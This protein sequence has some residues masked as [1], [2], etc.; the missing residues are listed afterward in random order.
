[1]YVCMYVCTIWKEKNNEDVMSRPKVEERDANCLLHNCQTHPT[2][3]NFLRSPP[4]DRANFS[5]TKVWLFL[6]DLSRM[7]LFFSLSSVGTVF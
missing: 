1:M 2:K 3:Q 5:H 6:G 7:V 4:G